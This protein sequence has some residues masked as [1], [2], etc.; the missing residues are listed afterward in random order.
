MTRT[1]PSRYIPQA[2]S[3]GKILDILEE[4]AS[5]P[6]N[7]DDLAGILGADRRQGTYYRL[8]AESIGLVESHDEKAHLTPRGSMLANKLV[9]GPEQIEFLRTVILVNPVLREVVGRLETAGPRGIL[10]SEITNLLAEASGISETTAQRRS[11]TVVEWLKT[12]RL[13]KV[14]HDRVFLDRPLL[15]LREEQTKT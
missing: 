1:I 14:R 11:R 4:L 2:D 8:A 7:D 13:A 9:E 5:G 6:A 12:L 10:F 15:H 3:I